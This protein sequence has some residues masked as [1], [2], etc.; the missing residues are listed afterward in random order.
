MHLRPISATVAWHAARTTSGMLIRHDW[1]F[2]AWKLGDALR[3]EIFELLRES[4]EAR[5]NQEFRTQLVEAARGP[6]K[7]IAE[8]FLRNHL[9]DGIRLN[10]F[11]PERCARLF[12]LI[13]RCLGAC[14]KLKHSQERYLD[15][16]K[17]RKKRP[18]D[19]EIA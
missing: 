6:C 11:S 19:D 4:P 1:E 2:D 18:Q 8:G 5:R 15:E 16:Q 17:R 12:V 10:Y 14:I 3:N 9:R 7:H 13:N